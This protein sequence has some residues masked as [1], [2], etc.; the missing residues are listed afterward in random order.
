MN[1]KKFNIDRG[2]L[3]KT[4]VDENGISVTRLVK[5]VGYKDRASFYAHISKPDLSFDILSNYAKVLN[6]DLR[7]DF[8]EI[9]SFLV[10]E[11]NENFYATPATLEEAVE[12]LNKWKAK[13]SQ[14]MEKHLRLM[15][16]TRTQ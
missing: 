13:Y 11:S 3:L 9:S 14:L 4:L 12:L 15:E 1:K 16:E 5:K 6:Y 2:K 7:Q 10:E 8:P